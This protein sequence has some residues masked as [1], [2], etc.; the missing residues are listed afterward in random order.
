MVASDA[1]T[2]CQ[3]SILRFHEQLPL[4]ESLFQRRHISLD[5]KY[6]NKNFFHAEKWS[7]GIIFFNKLFI[8]GLMGLLSL[9]GLLR[10]GELEF[11]QFCF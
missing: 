3:H 2:N 10:Y 11:N 7:S 4:L 5:C 6:S 8:L 9:E 1:T